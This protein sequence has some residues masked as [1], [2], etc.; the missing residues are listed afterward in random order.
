MVEIEFDFNQVKTNI[1][2]KLDDPFQDVINKF[3][4]KS[5]LEPGSVNFLVN[6]GL[7]NPN[8]SIESH[9]N[10]IDKKDN[11]M[12]IIVLYAENYDQYKEQVI[13][14][15]KDVICP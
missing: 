15:S 6:G 5:S 3:M 7:I 2:A 13:V 10:N 1:Q 9:M 14:T 4:Q 12:K 11:K 8:K